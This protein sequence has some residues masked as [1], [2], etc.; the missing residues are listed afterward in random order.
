MIPLGTPA[1]DFTLPDAI[2]GSSFSL[3]ELKGDNATVIMFIC[4][5]CPFVIH[6]VDQL[7]SLPLDYML[8]GISFTA[9]SSNDIISYPQDSPG[10]MREFGKKHGFS[11]P[12]LYDESQDVARSYSAACTPDFFIFNKD[13]RLVYRGQMDNSR[14][15]NNIPVTGSDIRNALD[16]VIE[17]KEVD[18][19]QRPSIGCSIKW[20]S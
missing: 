12:Y 6:V 1:Q 5:H 15:G 20:K 2:T 14:P 7:I 4:N 3:E 13:M 11:F 19:V 18:P 10:K 16:R 17:G 9:V 8:K